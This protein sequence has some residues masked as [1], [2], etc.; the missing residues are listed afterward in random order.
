M[1]E[2]ERRELLADEWLIVRNSGEIPEITFHSSLYYL[3]EDEEGPGLCLAEEEILALKEAAG[4]RYQEIILRDMDL[5]NFHK[6]IY[7]GIRRSIYNWERY[8]KFCQ[9][10]SISCG[11]FRQT[12]ARNLL[13][14]LEQ[15]K[16]G[17]GKQL[18]EVFINCSFF[19]LICFGQ[20]LGLGLEQLP[21][22]IYLFCLKH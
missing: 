17:A 2:E 3:T 16:S 14:F 13:F 10:Q 18:P 6:T 9:R 1:T 8:L 11:D 7:R 22:D 20:E 4:K 21:G 19:Q 15:G 5:D 12:V